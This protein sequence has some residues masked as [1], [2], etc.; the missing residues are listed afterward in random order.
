MI[1]RKVIVIAGPTASGKTALSIELAKRFDGEIINGDALQVYEGLNIG[2]AKI[3]SEEMEGVPHHL[4]SIRHPAESFSVADYQKMVRMKIEEISLRG[5]LPIIVGG[6]GLYIQSVL[7][8]YHFAEQA[9]DLELRKKLEMQSNDSLWQQLEEI[10]PDAAKEI[11]PNNKQRV[12]RAL[13]RILSSGI[14]KQ[15]ME[16]NT[17][18]D[19][20]YS[21]VIFGLERDRSELYER[22]NQRVHLMMENGLVDEV[23]QLLEDTPKDAQAF[24]AIGYKEVIAYLDGFSNYD[25]MIREIQQNSRR[26]AKRQFTYFRN[27]LPV[28]WV[29]PEIDRHKIIERCN[30]FL[31]D[32]SN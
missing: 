8:D 20:L 31:K 26:Y 21:F 11:H 28:E 15:Q 1:K 14:G 17:G 16:S 4:L 23:K 30:E 3:T 18:N 6:T 9:V 29:H 22:I 5:H 24:Q 19:P 32:N 7:F 25:E 10:D 27:K 13:E 2:T 12:V